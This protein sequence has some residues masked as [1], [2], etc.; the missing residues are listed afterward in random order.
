MNFVLPSEIIK[1]AALRGYEYGWS[2]STF[3]DAVA[4]AEAL[5]Y[6]CLGGQFQFR[7]DDATCEMYWLDADSDERILG[8]T[9]AAYSRRSCSEVL[10]KFQ[11]LISVTDFTKEASDWP[12]PLDP[13]N[14]LVFVAYFVT[15][16]DIAKTSD[17]P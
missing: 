13:T 11:H 16:T 5:G 6:A 12:L 8:E 7:L 15:E 1:G 9:W 14:N 17:A 4:M 3:P 2:I 10:H